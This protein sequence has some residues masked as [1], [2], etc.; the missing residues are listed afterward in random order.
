M[1]TKKNYLWFGL[2]E[3]FSH[4]TS[5]T[6][7]K[8]VSNENFPDRRVGKGCAVYCP[9]RCLDSTLMDGLVSVYC[10]KSELKQQASVLDMHMKC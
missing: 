8:S 6:K 1:Q 3:I 9:V 4:F 7:N 10:I 5:P 2:H